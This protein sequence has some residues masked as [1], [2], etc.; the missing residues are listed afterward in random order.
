MFEYFPEEIRL[1]RAGASVR[2]RARLGLM[3]VRMHGEARSLDRV[4]P[5][6]AIRRM[7]IDLASPSASLTVRSN[8]FVLFEIFGFGA[9]NVDLSALGEIRT[10][11]DAGAN[12]GLATVALARRLPSARFVCV[13]PSPASFALLEQNLN[14]NGIDAI[15]VNAALAQGR[16][17]SRVEEGRHPGRTRAIPCAARDDSTTVEA[18]TISD[19]LDIARVPCVDLMKLDTEG[20]EAELLACGT[21]WAGRV[22]AVL[23]EIHPPLGLNTARR[24]MRLLGYR[25][26]TLPNRPV[27][28]NMLFGIRDS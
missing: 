6:P 14:G 13:E 8:D 26:T 7:R 1:I 27:F 25:I 3:S 9:Y 11:L 17:R 5:F 20:G 21:K 16:G 18:L 10:V 4:V 12:V 24:K 28:S 15:A 22:R 19:V 23:A 2:D